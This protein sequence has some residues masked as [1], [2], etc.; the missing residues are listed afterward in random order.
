MP[1]PNRSPSL[2][3][4]ISI[5]IENG[6]GI[7]ASAK[8]VDLL[9]ASRSGY[10]WPQGAGLFAA[11]QTIITLEVA[12]SSHICTG[13]F[14]QIAIDV[15]DWAGNN[16]AAHARIV[17]ASAATQT[18]ISTAIHNLSVNPGVGL[19]ALC[20]IP[21]ISLVIAS[22]IFRFVQPNTGAAIDR[23]ASYFVNSLLVTNGEMATSFARE[24]ANS[25]RTSSR[26]AIYNPDTLLTNTNEYLE[27]YLPLLS[28]LAN[29]LNARGRPYMCAVT[30]TAKEW[31]PADIEMAMYHW[32]AN[33]GAR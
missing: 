10:E 30:K 1:A 27:K 11:Q 17:G 15:S 18:S 7:S 33:Y 5:T 26:L 8:L 13:N 6:G 20:S 32:W 16:A 9:F 19:N 28:G 29:Y 2:P 3:S 22:K 12:V 24:W 31:R 21:G 14:H 23:H 25:A 4:G